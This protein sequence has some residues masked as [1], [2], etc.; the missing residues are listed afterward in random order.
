MRRLLP[1]GYLVLA[2]AGQTAGS[3]EAGT[4]VRPKASMTRSEVFHLVKD[5]VFRI[6]SNGG[7][8]SGFLVDQKGLVVTNAHVINDPRGVSVEISQSL[9]VPATVVEL[10]ERR[11]IAVVAVNPLAVAGIAPLR[12]SGSDST[13]VP[14]GEEVMAIGFPLH[15]GR[16]VTHGIVSRTEKDSIISDVGTNPGNSGGPLL[17]QRGEVI[18]VNTFRD[19]PKQGPGIGGSVSSWVVMSIVER[20]AGREYEVPAFRRLPTM[21]TIA[22]PIGGRDWRAWQGI[23]YTSYLPSKRCLLEVDEE[24]G[25][26][27]FSA[28]SRTSRHVVRRSGMGVKVSTPVTEYRPRLQQVA[29][30]AGNMPRRSPPGNSRDILAPEVDLLSDMSRGWGEFVGERIPAVRI[31]VYPGINGDLMDIRL[32]MNGEVYEPIAK[33]VGPVNRRTSQGAPL[34]DVA[35]AG[36][37]VLPYQAFKPDLSSRYNSGAR[38]RLSKES[39]WSEHFVLVVSDA[40]DPKGDCAIAMDRWLQEQV[41][42]DFEP[43]RDFLAGRKAALL[44]PRE[45]GR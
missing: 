31:R 7:H 36:W 23:E 37:V 10:D 20:A 13:P 14:I 29:R 32:W 5:S 33:R 4:L 8:G 9:R 22:Y 1:I 41:W 45:K 17:N 43:Y 30:R 12:L 3:Q 25:G 24:G 34:L 15:Q 44:L 11:D 6:K 19:L 42:L 26:K 16:L 18:G 38:G 21:P 27:S 28:H 2:L 35:N 39:A 40:R